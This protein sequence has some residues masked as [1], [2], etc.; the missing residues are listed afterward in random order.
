M[1][2]IY[3][4]VEC[5]AILFDSTCIH[6]MPL[7]NPDCFENSLECDRGSTKGW[8]NDNNIDLTR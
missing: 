3:G 7:M 1:C 8:D 2:E 5:I 4:V 6:I